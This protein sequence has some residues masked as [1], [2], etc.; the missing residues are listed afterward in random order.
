MVDLARSPKNCAARPTGSKLEPVGL[1][2]AHLALDLA[3]QL[4]AHQYQT[5]SFPE[6]TTSHCSFANRQDQHEIVID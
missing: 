3:P 5:L 4:C 6:L 1:N 2:S